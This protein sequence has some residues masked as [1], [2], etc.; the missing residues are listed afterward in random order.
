M[1][2]VVSYYMIDIKWTGEIHYK[3][4]KLEYYD[5]F[6]YKNTFCSYIIRNLNLPDNTNYEKWWNEIGKKAL[7]EKV[8][9]LR[10]DRLKSLKWEYYGKDVC[11]G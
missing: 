1:D 6:K 9:S 7:K 5:V 4:R 3:R 11:V 8:I 10:N 2:L